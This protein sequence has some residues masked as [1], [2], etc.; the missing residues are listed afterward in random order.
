ME[1]KTITAEESRNIRKEKVKKNAEIAY[2][3]YDLIKDMKYKDV[4]KLIKFIEQNFEFQKDKLKLKVDDSLRSR[5]NT[6]F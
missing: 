6:W 5:T 1:N 3:V 2:K 4:C